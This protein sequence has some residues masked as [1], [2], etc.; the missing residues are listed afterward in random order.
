[1]RHYWLLLL[2]AILA[3]G[4]ASPGVLPPLADL[5][6]GE[7]RR[8]ADVQGVDA[9]ETALL[10]DLK[11]PG[12]IQHMW[13][14]ASSPDPHAYAHMV[15][16]VWWD[17]EVDPSIEA[18]LGDFFGTGF[19]EERH[20]YSAAIEMIPAGMPGHAALVSWI[21]MPFE[22]ARIEVENQTDTHVA[23]FSK[24]DWVKVRRLDPNAGRLHAQWRRSNPVEKGRPHVA[25][26]ARG[27]GRFLGMTF[28]IHRLRGGGWVE[29]GED[30][31]IDIRKDEWE[32]LDRWD[33]A[34]VAPERR[35]PEGIRSVANQPMGPVWP[36]L[37]GIGIED[38]FCHSWGFSEGDDSIYHGISLGPDE[39]NRMSAFRFHFADPIYFEESFMVL[40]R[41]H[42][43][44]VG[45]RSDDI[46][47][48][49]F[50]YQNEPHMAFPEL[51]TKEKRFTPLDVVED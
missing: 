39:Q 19:G 38:Y 13:F 34:L 7:S 47:T 33:R 3:G 22:T 42:G 41:N 51:P 35:V 6:V 10:A 36:T 9:G 30:F 40:I 11:G 8:A 14:T 32:A 50:W 25:L 44:D 17:G 15:L 12:V 18:P 4:C 1:M 45:P 26:Q 43:W 5:D 37:P 20:L 46:T 23:F 48:V 27:K 24:I 21:P 29:G 2:A 28:S 16:R 31:Y 49:A